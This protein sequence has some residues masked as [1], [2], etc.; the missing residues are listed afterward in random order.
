M[1]PDGYLFS[2]KLNKLITH[3]NHLKL[4]DEVKEKVQYILGST[5]VLGKKAGAILI[6]LPASFEYD[7]ERLDTFLTFFTKEVRAMEHPFDVAIEFRNKRWFTEE[8]FALLK[9]YNVAFVAG[10]SSRWPGVRKVTSD[11]V[12]IRMHGPEKLFASSYSAEQ[13]QELAS[14]IT[15]LPK[16]VRRVYVYFNNDFHGYALANAR[17]LAAL[18]GVKSGENS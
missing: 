9:K 7:L 3:I 18:L 15:A 13:L 5:Q 10:Q 14:Y 6:Q 17:D 16:R 12:Y 4:T 1:T 11:V 8:A 2:I